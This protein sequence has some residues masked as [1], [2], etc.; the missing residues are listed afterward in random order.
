[1][2]GARETLGAKFRASNGIVYHRG[3]HT[4]EIR[5]DTSSRIGEQQ[6][7]GRSSRIEVPII[8]KQV[9]R[10]VLQIIPRCNQRRRSL[11]SLF[12]RYDTTNR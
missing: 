6:I 9:T 1:M 7:D 10:K 8:H 4:T 12:F 3:V 5:D 11:K 2:L